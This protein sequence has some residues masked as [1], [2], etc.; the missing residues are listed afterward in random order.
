MDEGWFGVV[1]RWQKAMT[2]ELAN[3]SAVRLSGWVPRPS[4]PEAMV[5][6]I[7]LY[8]SVPEPVVF[9][10]LKLLFFYSVPQ[11]VN[12]QLIFHYSLFFRCLS[13]W[14]RE[15]VTIT[16]ALWYQVNGYL[17]QTKLGTVFTY[18]QANGRHMESRMR[19]F[20]DPRKKYPEG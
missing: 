20:G 19:N 4:H 7:R 12:L 2:S 1:C 3:E 5:G 9:W 16:G 18:R 6:G 17:I 14:C 8:G 11:I 10:H 13:R 15:V